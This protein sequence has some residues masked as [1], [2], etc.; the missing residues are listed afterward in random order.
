MPMTDDEIGMEAMF[1]EYLDEI[2]GEL[3]GIA[4]QL[5]RKP[6]A[7]I[8]PQ[9]K[10]QLERLRNLLGAGRLAASGNAP[11]LAITLLKLGDH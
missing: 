6:F 10:Q 11:E 7:A 2:A 5:R 4:E 8:E 9:L 1:A 3:N